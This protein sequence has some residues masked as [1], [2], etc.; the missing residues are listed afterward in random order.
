[1]NTKKIFFAFL[2]CATLMMAS[3]TSNSA[4]DDQLYNEQGIEKEKI[5]TTGKE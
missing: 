1:M 3:C 4:E 2:A 5:K